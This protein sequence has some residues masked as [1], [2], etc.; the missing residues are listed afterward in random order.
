[1]ERW[2][3]VHYDEI[4]L[5]GKNRAFFEKKFSSNLKKLLGGEV[6]RIYGRILVQSDL[7]E[8]EI[9]ERLRLQPGVANFSFCYKVPSR[10]GEMKEAALELARESKRKTFRIDAKKSIKFK[11]TNR[12]INELVG[13]EVRTKTKKKVDLSKP[14]LTIYI[15]LTER[16]TLIYKDKFKGI[17]GLPIGSSGK[18]ISLIS[19]G[20]DSPTAAYLAMKRGCDVVLVHFY[21]E[22]LSKPDKINELLEKLKV[23]NPELKLYTIPFAEIQRKIIAKVNSKYRMVIYRRIMNQIAEKIAEKE[24]AKGIVTGDSLGQ[25]ASQTLENMTAIDES[26]K[27][28]TLRPLLTYN[29]NDI[30]ELA[31]KIGTYNISIKPYQDCCSFLVAK[32]PVTKAKIEN[33][34]EIEK[35]LNKSKLIRKGINNSSVIF[36]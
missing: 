34:K 33:V 27:L 12:E 21:N 2:V 36:S 35:N 26:T 19:G 30:I 13:E 3:L 25:V 31:Q 14:G 15:E 18:V 7:R 10:I 8:K 17:G 1:M 22:T 5:K 16:G 28:P 9:K 29:K 4:A 23:I 20:I 24:K 11:K 6:L 32:H